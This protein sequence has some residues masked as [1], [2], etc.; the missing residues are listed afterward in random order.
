[1]SRHA[2]RTTAGRPERQPVN[3]MLSAYCCWRKRN[4]IYNRHTVSLVG[5][6][7]EL[8]HISFPG[9]HVPLAR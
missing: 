2:E 9:E 7:T 4:N 6:I 1:M 8:V 5:Y 3:T